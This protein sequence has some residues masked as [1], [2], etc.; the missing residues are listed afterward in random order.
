MKKALIIG[1]GSGIGFEIAKTLS[2]NDYVVTCVGRK[3]RENF[4]FEYVKCDVSKGDEVIKLFN[5]NVY[6]VLVYC[7]GI[8]SSEEESFKYNEEEINSIID[9]NLK[10]CI[11]TNQIFIDKCLENSIS[12]KIINISSISNKGSKYFPI[13]ASSKAG[14]LAYTRSIASRYETIKANIISPGVIKTDMSYHE[15][16]DFDQYIPSIVLNT[17]AKRLGNTVDIANAVEF[18]LSDKAEFITG[19]ELIVDGGY[20]L[21]KE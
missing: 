18:L 4:D 15:T 19:Q 14:I 12:G 11:R 9:I 21:P 6:D 10:G 3:E 8:I 2:S 1:G 16:P 20:T 5:N 7:A 17:P 13:Y